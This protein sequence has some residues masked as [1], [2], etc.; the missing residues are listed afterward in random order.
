MAYPVAAG[1]PSYSGSFIPEIWSP[2]LQVKFYSA[3]VFGEIA[4]TEYEGEIKAHGDR[5]RIRTIPS[6]T[7]RSYQKGQQLQ[8]EQPEASNI[9]L[10]I[11]QGYYFQFAANDVDKVQS[12]L[13][14]IDLWSKDA[15]MQ[16]KIAVDT[17]ILG[18]VYSSV[19]SNNQGLTAGLRSQAF[20]LG[21]TGTPVALTKT[22]IIDSILDL[23]VVLSE[24]NIPEEDRWVVLPAWACGLIKRSD[25][26]DASLTGDG[27][28]ILRNGRIGMIDNFTIYASNNLTPV[29]D[30]SNTCYNMM[31]GHKSAITFASQLVT[32]EQ[33]RNPQDFGDIIR[34]LH[35]YGFSVI[36]PQAL[37][38]L[39]GY[40]G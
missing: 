39:Y 11:N 24:Q 14:L 23:S 29:T 8:T 4:N 25:L 17:Q 7:V 16:L 28:S 34:G 30:G 27:K 37:A 40:K 15:S 12:D 10:Y 32:M 35:V 33:L 22:N 5:V 3:T 38:V 26:K 2:K 18:T 20:N 13:R 9:D 1:S 21:V 6:L 19:D 36:K 31:A